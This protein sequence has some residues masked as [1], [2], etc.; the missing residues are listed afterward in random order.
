M[1]LDY[2]SNFPVKKYEGWQVFHE[3]KGKLYPLLNE[4][5]YIRGNKRKTVPVGKW[6]RDKNDFLL[7][8]NAIVPTK[9]GY[10]LPQKYETGFHVF[11]IKRDAK[12]F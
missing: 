3:H 12:Y 1:S 11:P 7:E 8:T 5:E 6:E 9:K 4:D 2:L 10:I